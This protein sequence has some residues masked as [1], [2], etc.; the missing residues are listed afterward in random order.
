MSDLSL[1]IEVRLEL[2]DHFGTFTKTMVT[3]FEITTVNWVPTCR[4]VMS[5]IGEGI[6]YIII[7][8]RCLFCFAVVNVIRAVFMAETARVASAD[9]EVAMLKRDRAAEFMQMKMKAVFADLDQTGDG[10]VTWDEFSASLQDEDVM[11]FMHIL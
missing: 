2:F 1:P 10:L 4:L 9:D 3:M 5:H 7:F 11:N 8:Y 6:A